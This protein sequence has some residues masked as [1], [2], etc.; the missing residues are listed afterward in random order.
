M[1]KCVC[2]SDALLHIGGKTYCTGCFTAGTKFGA[3]NAEKIK[4]TE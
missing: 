1:T 3:A 2:G 4:A